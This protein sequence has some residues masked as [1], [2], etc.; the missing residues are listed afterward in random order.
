MD[1][2]EL[3]ENMRRTWAAMQE[4]GGGRP[5]F[6]AIHPS[7]L[8]NEALMTELRAAAVNHNFSIRVEGQIA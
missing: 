5:D 1:A 2:H 3:I 6:V 8:G 7:W 4:A